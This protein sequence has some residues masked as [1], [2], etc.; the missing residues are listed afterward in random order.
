MAGYPTQATANTYSP[1]QGFFRHLEISQP[2]VRVS[3]LG[4]G[5]PVCTKEKYF[6]II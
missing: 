2:T 5:K 3:L 1:G 4:D 6:V